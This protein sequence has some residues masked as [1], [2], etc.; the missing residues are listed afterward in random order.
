ML[1]LFKFFCKKHIKKSIDNSNIGK[2]KIEKNFYELDNPIK[3]RLNLVKQLEYLYYLNFYLISIIK[4]RSFKTSKIIIK[5]KNIIQE[6]IYNIKKVLVL[7]SNV[8]LNKNKVYNLFFNQLNKNKIRKNKDKNLERILKK[9][10]KLD[11]E[12]KNI[13]KE[14]IN[15]ALEIRLVRNN[16]S[17]LSAY[18]EKGIE[19][20]LLIEKNIEKIKEIKKEIKEENNLLVVKINN[21]IERIKDVKKAL[22]EI[23][24]D[25]SDKNEQKTLKD[26]IKKKEQLENLENQNKN[27][28]QRLLKLSKLFIAFENLNLINNKKTSKLIKE[29]IKIEKESL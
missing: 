29:Y 11:T 23:E 15:L 28:N 14:Y 13:C 9:Y 26:R 24:I 2:K 18:D 7:N 19:I 12:T 8:K 20:K 27:I 25:L 22:K 17:D 4:F 5:N 3:N 1:N 21:Y 16:L 6:I 10:N